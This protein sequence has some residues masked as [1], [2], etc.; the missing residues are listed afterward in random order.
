MRAVVLSDFGRAPELAE[1]ETPEPGPD[2]VRVRVHAASVNGFD[3][4]VTNGYPQAMME[5]RFPVVLGKDFAGVID[6]VGPNIDGFQSGDRV[7]G[8]ALDRSERPHQ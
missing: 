1:L 7:F 5:H 6:A 4:A 2:E 3:V 8:V